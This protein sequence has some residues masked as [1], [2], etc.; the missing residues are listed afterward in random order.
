M[1]IYFY[2]KMINTCPIDNFLFGLWVISKLTNFNNIPNLTNTEV[3]KQIV[4][5]INNKDWYNAKKL[6]ILN[7]LKVKINR[8]NNRSMGLERAKIN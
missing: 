7:V 5:N 1:N 6:W 4:I 2:I 8:T 3:I